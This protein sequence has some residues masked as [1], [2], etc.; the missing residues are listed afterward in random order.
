M[1]TTTEDAMLR[2]QAL[3]LAHNEGE[4]PEKVIDRAQRYYDFLAGN[5]A[6]EEEG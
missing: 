3:S 6:E 5:K 4:D 2:G 1:K